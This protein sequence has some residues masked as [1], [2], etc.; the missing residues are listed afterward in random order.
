M[1]ESHIA[2]PAEVLYQ[3]MLEMQL[4]SDTSNNE[5]WPMFISFGPAQP[6]EAI[7]LYDTAG[8]HDGRL[9]TGERIVHP[10]VQI[11]V[12]GAN[13]AEVYQRAKFISLFLADVKSMEV[14][15]STLQVYEIVNISQ[16]GD[17]LPMGLIQE[18]DRTNFN[19]TINVVLTI[20]PSDTVPDSS[21][22][23]VAGNRIVYVPNE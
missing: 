17:L 2:S 23:L 20:R 3:L 19:F 5:L 6:D 10:G 16:P 13:Y 1:T 11:R 4:G 7:F 12:R 8:I 14:V 15:V 22:L 9:M 21:M 18:G